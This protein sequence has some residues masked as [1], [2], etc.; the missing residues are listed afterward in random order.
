MKRWIASLSLLAALVVAGCLSQANA[1][2]TGHM[3]APVAGSSGSVP[4]TLALSTDSGS[5]GHPVVATATATNNGTTKVSYPDGCA[6][7]ARIYFAV[8]DSDG[9]P[10]HLSDPTALPRVCPV[11]LQ[12]MAPSGSISESLTFSG[13]LYHAAGG[14]Y[15]A[16]AGTYTIVANFWLFDGEAWS[17]PNRLLETR[18]TLTW[19]TTR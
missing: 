5:P 1:P 10:V 16:P 3:P 6:A 8:L 18:A 12:G 7:Y 9:Q 15:A 11:G 17:A 2:T 13:T 4:L 19:A 14:S